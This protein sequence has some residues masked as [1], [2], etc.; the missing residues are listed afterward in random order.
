MKE[1]ITLNTIIPESLSGLRLDQALAKCFPDYSRAKLTEWVREGSV[2]VDQQK[3]PPKRKI[4]GGEVIDVHAEQ[5]VLTHEPEDIPL[6]IVYEDDHILVINKAADCVVHPGAGNWEGTLLNALLHHCEDQKHLP[7]AGIIHRLDK[8]TTGLMVVTK[9]QLANTKLVADLSERKIGRYYYA[10]V[11]GRILSGGTIDQPIGR[12]THNRLKMAVIKGGK[13]AVTHYRVAQRF[14]GYTLLDVKLET[15]RTHQIRVHMSHQ[16]NSLIGDG[17][18]AGRAQLMANLTPSLRETIQNFPRP[19]LHAYHL[20]LEHPFT[21]QFMEWTLPIP[22]D[23]QALLKE[24]KANES[25]KTGLASPHVD[26]SFHN[27]PGARR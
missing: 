23:M 3:W 9:S 8:D 19:A 20:H 5:A 16:N 4:F 15:G 11:R 6:D 25:V 22:E 14:S 24:L 12:H 1:Q 18:Y 2:L 7:R 27:L 13:P 21:G 10:V 17:R 26:T